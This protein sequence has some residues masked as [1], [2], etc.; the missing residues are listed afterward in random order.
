MKRSPKAML[1]RPTN[2]GLPKC[3][4]HLPTMESAGR[5]PG[6][7]GIRMIHSG[8]VVSHAIHSGIVVSH[9]ILRKLE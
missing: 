8:I 6:D 1:L 4:C 5:R 7:V 9:A 3:E 2:V